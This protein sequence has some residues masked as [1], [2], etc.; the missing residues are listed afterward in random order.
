MKGEKEKSPAVNAVGVHKRQSVKANSGKILSNE[1]EVKIEYGC[2]K[3]SQR[4]DVID[5]SVQCSRHCHQE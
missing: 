1:D 3:T 4:A 5:L 2:T